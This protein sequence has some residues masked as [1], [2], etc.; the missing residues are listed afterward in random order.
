[1]AGKR[2]PKFTPP[3]K[4]EAAPAASRGR[5]M[6]RMQA[7]PEEDLNSAPQFVGVGQWLREKRTGFIH[8]W[9]E[10]MAQ[11]SDLVELYDPSQDEERSLDHLTNFDATR[12]PPAGARI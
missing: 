8:P 10:A 7:V 11:R 2:T 5:V 12:L 6:D 1:M 3:A 4:P 9:N